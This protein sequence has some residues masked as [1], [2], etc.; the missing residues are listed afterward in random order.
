MRF[1]I[2]VIIPTH[3]KSP[4][5]IESVKAVIRA[6]LESKHLVQIIISDSSNLSDTL[7][8]NNLEDV[9]NVQIDIIKSKRGANSARNIGLDHSLS[10]IVLFLDDD[11][12]IEDQHF[13]KKHLEFHKNNINAIACG[14]FYGL[15]SSVSQLDQ[16]Y[17]EGQNDWLL[18]G[19]VNSQRK[20]NYL[21]GGNVSFKNKLLAQHNLKFDEHILYG[22]SETELFVRI[23]K[24][25]LQCFLIN[26][27]VVHRCDLTLY[28]LC[29]K[30]YRQGCGKKY[31]EKKL[32][33]EVAN[34]IYVTK[35]GPRLK[36]QPWLFLQ[37]T[38]FKLGY[39]SIK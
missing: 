12:I 27:N 24:L 2:S 17:I 4:W 34:S 14:G 5:L 7:K 37:Q 31:R 36:S 11:C 6:S 30:S 1:D 32:S 16:F 29:K 13:L 21:L 28:E 18:R 38:F 15:A 25:D 39:N 35:A 20:I 10:D 8:M 23:K 3:R 9:L 26:A 19:V 22:G 33:F